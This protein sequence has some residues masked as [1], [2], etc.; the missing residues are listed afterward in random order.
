MQGNSPADFAPLAHALS[1]QLLSL[2][3]RLPV[4]VTGVGEASPFFAVLLFFA[5]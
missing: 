2:D 1:C 4:E 3:V 5:P